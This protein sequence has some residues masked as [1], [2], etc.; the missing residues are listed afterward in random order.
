[1]QREVPWDWWAGDLAEAAVA[2]AGRPVL[3]WA[4]GV[5]REFFGEN[6]L[7]E[8]AASS[9]YVPFLNHRWLPLKNSRVVVR[10]L[11]LA[12]RIALVTA[13]GTNPDVLHDART[14]YASRD[15][16]KTKFEHLCL[17]LEVAAF[18]VLA[19]WTASYEEP[20]ASGRR[21]DLTLR[22]NAAACTVEVTALGLDREFRAI[23]RYSDALQGQLHGLEIRHHVDLTCR[24]SE[25]LADMDLAAWLEKIGRACAQTASDG[26][27]RT[28]EQG[29]NQA[30][31]FPAGERPG[32][33]VYSG[34][35]VRSEVWRRVAVRIGQK[36]AQTAG[37]PAWLRIDDTGALFRLTD[38]STQPLEYLLADLQFNAAIALD[39]APHVRGIVL[40]GGV[41]RNPG[42]GRKETSWG[43]AG[44]EMLIAPGPSRRALADGPAAMS[45]L[46]PG[47]RMR[48]T[49]ILPSP[50]PYLILPSGTGLEPGMWYHD[51]PTW[52]TRA[53]QALGHPPLG[54][55]IHS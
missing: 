26:R 5:I 22:R 21:P 44:P 48:L 24:A 19:G 23:Q 1:M 42:N 29:E 51:E 20:A 8:N 13:S 2:P 50:D 43:Q 40:S 15:Q 14:I 28:I 41:L 32:K 38:R 39:G 52:L 54:Q 55:L 11:E 16:A 31:V 47:G 17:T 53:L 27:P 18:A 6:W 25:V 49:F 4:I 33:E 35:A 36:A 7:A 30:S 9:G 46:L 12:A 37:G 10:V 3:M 45:R 34:P